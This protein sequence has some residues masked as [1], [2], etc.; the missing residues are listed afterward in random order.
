MC[1][2]KIFLN[3]LEHATFFGVWLSSFDKVFG[4]T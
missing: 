3:T 2:E 4:K 1:L